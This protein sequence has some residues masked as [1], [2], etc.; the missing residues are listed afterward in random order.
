MR[1]VLNTVDPGQQFWVTEVGYNVGFDV[2]GPKN[3]IP[4]QTDA[5]QVAFMRDVYEL[6]AAHTA[7]R[8]ARGR[9]CVLVQVRG[10]SAGQRRECP[11]LG[12]GADPFA[13]APALAAR[14]M[15]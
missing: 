1:A 6:L 7:R 2:D 5:G 14:A 15:I 4:A 3:P 13:K 12:G 8:T 11:A 10:F 9:Q